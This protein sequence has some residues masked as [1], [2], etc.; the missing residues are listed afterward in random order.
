M[1][2]ENDVR[3]IDE[4]E[5]QTDLSPSINSE[6]L[7]KEVYALRYNLCNTYLFNATTFL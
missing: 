2:A 6:D 3:E 7:E 1:L 4:K 5:C